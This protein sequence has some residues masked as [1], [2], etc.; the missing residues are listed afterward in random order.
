MRNIGRKKIQAI[1]LMVT[2]VVV[3]FIPFVNA[4][5][6]N[7]ISQ[8]PSERSQWWN[9]DWLNRKLLTIDHT[10]VS[11]YLVNFPILI[12]L[13]TDS[14][15]AES[16]QSTGHDI[17][18]VLFSDNTTKLN[19]EIERFNPTNGNLIAWVNIPSLSSTVDTKIWMYYGN[20]VSGDQ[21]NIYV[22]WNSE[23]LMVHHMEE[24]GNINDSTS[25]AL[26]AINYETTSDS[27]GKIGACRCFNNTVDRFDFGDNDLLNPGLNSWTITLWTKMDYVQNYDMMKKYG[28]NAGFFI[29]VN[30]GS[31]GCNYIKVS[32]GTN[33]AARWWDASWSDGTWHFFSVVI[34][35]ITNKLDV[36]LDG[37]L[38]NGGGTGNITTVGSIASL[39][40]FKLYGGING[41][42]D[43]FTVS[44]TIRDANW[45]KTSYINQNDPDSFYS[46]GTE[47]QD[48]YT[49]TITVDGQ[50]N[51]TKDPDLLTYPYGTN[52]TLTAYP[53]ADWS[54]DH[55]S[56][57]L[58]GDLNPASILI[59]EDKEVTATFILLDTTPVAINDTSTV[60]E[61]SSNTTID[62]LANDYDPDGDNL[63]ITTVT[64]P[65]HGTSSQDGA[66]IYYTPLA[67]YTG[68]DSFTYTITDGQDGNA[69][70]TVFIT[71][72]PPNTP[73]YKPSNPT[74]QSG[75]T[76]VSITTDLGWIGG[77]PDPDDTVTY[78]IYFGTT[79]SPGL[80][81]S[82]HS[83][84]TYDLGILAYDTT[85]YW[86]IVS[87]DSHGASNGGSLWS[88]TTQSQGG[89]GITV[90]ITRPLEKSFYLRNFRLFPLPRNTIVY[91]PITIK[92]KV[93]ADT[94]VDRVEFYI[95][96]KIRKTDT[97]AP[98]TYRWAPLKSF[99][100]TI[101][102]IA[103][104][105][106]NH[107]ATDEITVFK[108]RLHPI[109]LMSGAFL[110][111]STCN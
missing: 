57:D 104:D 96:G 36:Y 27:N 92:A 51:V 95:D 55:W 30:N 50:G 53:D 17:A 54:F 80:I 82:N 40:T 19:H 26:N 38:H 42:Q 84:A 100:H 89:G 105:V 68:S 44:T 4:H 59:D 73:P 18:F 52:V 85:Y 99:K 91:G 94:E 12:S 25:H 43:D 45:I 103:Y 101:T 21:Q 39:T 107:S 41:K 79:P 88:F 71:V 15:L 1:I 16:A 108:W 24:T 72:I 56:G 83:T 90:N 75:M 70:A 22:T 23:Y 69:S 6:G 10:K 58:T 93:V 13:P 7:L 37:D 98:Y 9:P 60:L 97:R 48:Q 67:S 11:A 78:T 61:N 76:N 29:N 5:R 66:Y 31:N 111:S 46:V 33:S 65:L 109:L 8:T 28:S 62:A 14:D 64:Q 20:N 47:E 35:R 81:E 32:D 34:N 102:V 77:D 2:L 49:L 74:P 110:L 87:W 63:T 86:R 3:T 106:Q